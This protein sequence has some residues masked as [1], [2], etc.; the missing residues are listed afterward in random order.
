VSDPDARRAFMEAVRR[1]QKAA[2]VKDPTLPELAQAARQ[3]RLEAL[4]SRQHREI[5]RWIEMTEEEVVRAC[6][7]MRV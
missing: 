2:R 3:A 4:D 5:R 1:V 6:T 7:M